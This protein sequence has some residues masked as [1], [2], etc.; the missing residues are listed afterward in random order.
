M[1]KYSAELAKTLS[2]V[3]IHRSRVGDTA[4]PTADSTTPASRP[5][6]TVVWMAVCI[7]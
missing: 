7:F 6:A 2:G 4:T 5:K 1:R 3:P